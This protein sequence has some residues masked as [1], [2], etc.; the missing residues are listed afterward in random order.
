MSDKV[1]RVNDAFVELING[2]VDLGCGSLIKMLRRGSTFSETF[3]M[4]KYC[5]SIRHEAYQVAHSGDW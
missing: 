2:I 3:A 1:C 4:R 5:T